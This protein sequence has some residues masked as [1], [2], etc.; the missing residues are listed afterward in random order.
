MW[1]YAFE[2]WLVGVWEKNGNFKPRYQVK[3]QSQ[4]ASLVN[5][6]NGGLG[7]PIDVLF[8]FKPNKAMWVFVNNLETSFFVGYYL[9][10]GNFEK[11]YEVSTQL[12]AESLVN[13]LNG[14]TGDKKVIAIDPGPED[15]PHPEHLPA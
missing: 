10:N 14:G 1:R 13:Y 4:A 5:Y 8:K 2:M 3:L 12:Q 15:Q 7:L 11:C 6:L 9:P